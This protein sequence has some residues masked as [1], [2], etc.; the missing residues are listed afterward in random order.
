MEHNLG[1]STFHPELRG[2]GGYGMK[3][4]L[5]SHALQYVL[6]E[7]EAQDPANTEQWQIWFE[8][9]KTVLSD[10]LQAHHAQAWRQDPP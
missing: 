7:I 1:S 9:A 10:V 3:V 2:E 8:Q 6:Q 5:A 4:S